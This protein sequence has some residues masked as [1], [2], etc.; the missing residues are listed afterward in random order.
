MVEMI[1]L[2]LRIAETSVTARLTNCSFVPVRGL[3]STEP[4]LRKAA[5]AAGSMGKSSVPASS[6]A[7]A[8]PPGAARIAAGATGAETVAARL[9][10]VRRRIAAAARMAGREPD[11]VALV[12]VGKTMPE[13]V[14]AEALAAGHRRFGENRG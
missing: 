9:A 14:I 2:L 10:D 3:Y 11:A 4:P 7:N 1:L 12:A 5:H 13:A 8:A 6:K